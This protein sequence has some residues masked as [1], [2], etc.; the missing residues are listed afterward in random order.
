MTS[1]FTLQGS[2]ACEEGQLVLDNP[3]HGYGPKDLGRSLH[4]EGGSFPAGRKGREKDL[5]FPRSFE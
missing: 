5:R 4:C 1:L 2:C 3:F